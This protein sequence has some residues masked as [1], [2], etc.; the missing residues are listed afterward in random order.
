MTYPN[1]VRKWL[2]SV[3]VS[4]HGCEIRTVAFTPHPITVVCESRS[5]RS[6]SPQQVE[7]LIHPETL[8]D[9]SPLPRHLTPAIGDNCTSCKGLM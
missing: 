9:V 7:P 8:A 4:T 6:H 1:N 5:Y 3:G 2:D